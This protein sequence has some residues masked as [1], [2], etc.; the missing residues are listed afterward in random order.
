MVF[1]GRGWGCGA[2]R[3][4]LPGLGVG[5]CAFVEAQEGLALDGEAADVPGRAGDAG[6]GLEAFADGGDGEG[7]DGVF[8]VPGGDELS[9]EDVH[10]LAEGVL[11]DTYD[12]LTR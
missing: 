9:A 7:E 10:E 11:A 5:L 1:L 8:A 3:G 2:R 4:R 6:G 12:Q